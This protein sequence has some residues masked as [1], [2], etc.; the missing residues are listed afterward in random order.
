MSIVE[1]MAMSALLPNTFAQWLQLF[2][3]DGEPERQHEFQ[4]AATCDPTGHAIWIVNP[5]AERAWPVARPRV[6]GNLVAD[7]GFVPPGRNGT[8]SVLWR[9]WV[10]AMFLP[11][12][13]QH[14]PDCELQ[15]E[16]TV[17]AYSTVGTFELDGAFYAVEWHPGEIQVMDVV[18]S[19]VA[20]MRLGPHM[21]L[22]RAAP[23]AGTAPAELLDRLRACAIDVLGAAAE[24][25]RGP[26][27]LLPE[28]T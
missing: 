15:K 16:A 3:K 7:M 8:Y 21:V 18:G 23:G 24:D 14:V 19:P 22:E 17:G 1:P 25:R 28:R 6:R 27:A 13:L 5:A 2:G 4:M 12:M 11:R 26:F 9:T 20:V 10:R